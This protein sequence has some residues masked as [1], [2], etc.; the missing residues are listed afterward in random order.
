MKEPMKFQRTVTYEIDAPDAEAAERAWE[1]D[2]PECSPGVQAVAF[3]EI[4][5]TA[6]EPANEPPRRV[7]V[8]VSATCDLMER[9][10]AD[11][12]ANTPEAEVGDAAFHEVLK[13]DAEFDSQEIDGERDRNL[14]DWEEV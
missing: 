2:G 8:R 6:V 10:I 3:S 13:G 9:W 12:P 14:V 11:I 4:E 1:D 5:A 7:R